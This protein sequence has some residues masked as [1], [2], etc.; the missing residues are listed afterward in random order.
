MLSKREIFQN[1]MMVRICGYVSV[2]SKYSVSFRWESKVEAEANRAMRPTTKQLEKEEEQFL[3]K[4][5]TPKSDPMK[6]KIVREK[7]IK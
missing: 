7:E 6:M 4:I 5:G 2:R 1:L 3:M